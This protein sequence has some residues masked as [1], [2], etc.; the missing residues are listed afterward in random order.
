MLRLGIAGMRGSMVIRPRP[1]MRSSTSLLSST[2]HPTP[3]TKKKLTLYPQR[4]KNNG[5][6]HLPRISKLETCNEGACPATLHLAHTQHL[7]GEEADQVIEQEYPQAVGDD[8]PALHQVDPQ[9]EHQH[10]HEETHPSPGRV[11]H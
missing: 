6:K 5:E 4:T 9:K 8:E 11:D 3:P 10:R 7:G 1:C 2:P